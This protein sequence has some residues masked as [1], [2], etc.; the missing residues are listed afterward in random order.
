MRGRREGREIGKVPRGRGR[1][2]WRARV[3]GKICWRIDG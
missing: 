2:A 3:G 1:K